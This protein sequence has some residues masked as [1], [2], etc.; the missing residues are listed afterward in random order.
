MFVEQ[1]V[2]VAKIRTGHVPVK[3]LGLRLER[4]HIREQCREGCGDILCRLWGQVGG[5]IELTRISRVISSGWEISERWLDFTSMVLQPLAHALDF[6]LTRALRTVT[7]RDSR[8]ARGGC[9][10]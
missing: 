3:I 6:H 4:E 1:K 5:G 2:I 8:H 9:P 10:A 7:P